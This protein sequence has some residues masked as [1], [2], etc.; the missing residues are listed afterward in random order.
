MFN[1]IPNARHLLTLSLLFATLLFPVHTR[2]MNKQFDGSFHI[3]H[4]QTRLMQFENL[5]RVDIGNPEVVSISLEPGSSH[6]ILNGLSPGKTDITLWGQGERIKRYEIRVRGDKR[7]AERK[8]LEFLIG[9]I[10]GARLMEDPD[11]DQFFVSGDAVSTAD[12]N[13]LVALASHYDNVIV[14]AEKPVFDQAETVRMKIRF[15]EISTAA[16]RNI[17]IDWNN[18]VS[19]FQIGVQR[20]YIKSPFNSSE[21]STRYSIGLDTPL[22]TAVNILVQN[23]KGRILKEQSLMV[24]SGS[25]GNIFTGGEFPVTTHAG[26][27]VF[28]TEYRPFGMSL[29][30]NPVVNR[31]KQISSSLKFE[32]SSLDPTL[33]IGGNP[34]L[35]TTRQQTTL[36]MKDKQ[37][38]II[39][40]F[41]GSEDAKTVRKVPG[42]GHIPVFGEFFKS[43][44]IQREKTELFILLEPEIVSTQQPEALT[45]FN[46]RSDSALEATRFNI[47]D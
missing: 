28:S 24:Q 18:L 9:D 41:V 35:R 43:R 23:G 10:D 20:D 38:V 4:K 6:F 17:G 47:L 40:D 16:L 25:A 29:E 34:V 33:V 32:M 5:R 37:A 44:N 1:S 12:Y 2:A 39:G 30:V 19:G 3:N 36:I 8:T 13:R 15:L 14:N 21:T 27:G 7:I 42:L 31:N 46:N 11:S 26:D 45:Y 22:S